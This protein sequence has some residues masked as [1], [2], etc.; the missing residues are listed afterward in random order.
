VILKLDFEKAFDKLEHEVILQVL[1]HK[2]FPDRWNRWIKDILSSDT[3]SILLNGVPGKVF[4]CRRGVRQGDP[5]SPLLF[6]LAADL[7]QSIVNKAKDIGLLR[8]PIN[9]RCTLDFPI[10]QYADDTLL[11]MEACPEQLF[12][13]KTLL[14]TFADSTGLKINYSKSS[15]VPIN[16]SPDRLRH[17]A[18][19]YN[20]V[21]GSLPFTY[22]GLPLSNSGPTIQECLPLVH[23]IERRFLSTSMFLTQGGKLLMVNLVLSSLPIFYMC[24]IKVPIE[25]LNQIDKYRR[26]CL[27]HDGDVNDKKP[28]VA[29]WKLVCRPKKRGGIGII[30]LRLQNEALFMKN[31]DKFFNKADLPWVKLIWSQYY[32]N[33]KL[34]DQAM[35]GSFWAQYFK[36]IR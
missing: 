5:L 14:N 3:S 1:R 10:L 35:K 28:P 30:R 2:C 17:L 6:V 9:V 22:L 8:L 27:W 11:I 33:G 32:N 19:T 36:I 31:L 7:L 16:L 21:A 13:L 15:M 20:C 25:V 34:P 4:H 18:A 24:S 12:V 29:S 23:R 26:H